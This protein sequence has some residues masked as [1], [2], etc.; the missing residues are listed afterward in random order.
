MFY[1]VLPVIG[2]G[3]GITTVLFGFGGGFLIVPVL[4][5]GISLAYGPENLAAQSAMHIAVATSTCLMIFSS[6][7]ATRSHHKKG[8]LQ[9]NV[10][11]PLLGYIALGALIGAGAGTLVDGE[12]L[13]WA[14][15]LYL[16]IT[17]ADCVFRPGFTSGASGRTCKLGKAGS[18]AAGTLIG[19][20]AASLGVG[21]SVMTVPLL[22]RCGA[23]MTQATAMASPLT[24]PVSLAG[25]VGFVV[26]GW[27][28]GLALGAGHLGYV[29]LRALLGLLAGSWLGVKLAERFIGRLSDQ[30]HARSYVV[31]LVVF[32]LAMLV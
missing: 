27:H 5:Q 20:I 24:L 32:W 11:R 25:T 17:I 12:W 31:L 16:G 15:I 3:A 28:E 29:D 1:A 2:L 13:R 23:S 10:I 9:W 7:M 22:R 6:L 21:G 18:A 19:G 14:F 4:F 26:F 30:W 8:T